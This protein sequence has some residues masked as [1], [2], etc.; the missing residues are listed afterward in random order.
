M[1]GRNDMA[2]YRRALEGGPWPDRL[3]PGRLIL[4]LPPDEQE[5]LR[6]LKPEDTQDRLDYY[7]GA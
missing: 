1:C 5:S 7:Y 6:D 4:G 3:L 2:D